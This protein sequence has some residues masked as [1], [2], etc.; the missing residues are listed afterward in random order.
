ML[1][2]NEVNNKDLIAPVIDSNDVSGVATRIL[3]PGLKVETTILRSNSNSSKEE[4][5]TLGETKIIE[6]TYFTVPYRC[7]LNRDSLKAENRKVILEIDTIPK[8]LELIVSN[9]L[10]DTTL[11]KSTLFSESIFG[12]HLLIPQKMELKPKLNESQNWLFLILV[13]VLF[14]LGILRVF[15]Q[16]KLA[17]FI[18][19]FIS[20]R[21]SNQI[22]REENALT[23]STSVILSIV[24]FISISLFFYLTSKFFHQ[25]TGSYSNIQYFFL[26]LLGCIAFYFSKFI[27]NKLGGH[28]FKI[29]KETDEYIFNQFLVLQILGILLT[30]W[31]ILL[32]YSTKISKEF[33]IYIGFATLLM[34]F[35]VRMIKGFGIANMN[36]YSPV[37]IFLYLCTLE[38]LPLIIIV[39]LIIR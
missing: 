1:Q 14:L 15:Y 6:K 10:R 26:I 4:K 39:K 29:H 33:I 22:I 21:F 20:R 37:Y 13:F 18:N 9:S 25:N 23:Q 32:N 16:K 12:N 19:A 3:N 35:V 17:L 27:T 11:L 28:V 8:G 5:D 2:Q 31:C 38:I 24:F 36:T 30:M 34:G 7:T